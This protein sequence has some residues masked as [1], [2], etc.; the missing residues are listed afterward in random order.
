MSWLTSL[1]GNKP[2]ICLS[3][4]MYV[5]MSDSLFVGLSVCLSV[6]LSTFLS[7]CLSFCLS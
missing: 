7:V 5:C 3:V 1:K 6:F 4:G 2:N